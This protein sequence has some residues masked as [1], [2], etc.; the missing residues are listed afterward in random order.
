MSYSRGSRPP[1]PTSRS[2]SKPKYSSTAGGES[3]SKVR[4]AAAGRTPEPTPELESE[5]A[6]DAS[7][8]PAPRAASEPVLAETV[9]SHGSASS[10]AGV[11]HGVTRDVGTEHPKVIG[12]GTVSAATGKDLQGPPVKVGP[13]GLRPAGQGTAGGD[14]GVAEF[15]KRLAERKRAKRRLW[16]G[17][18]AGFLAIVAVLG[19]LAYLIGWSAA[20]GVKQE[21]IDIEGAQSGLQQDQVVATLQPYVGTPLIRV[22]VGEAADE[23]R[24]LPFVSE[25]S[26]SRAWPTGL[27]VLIEERLP[28]MVVPQADGYQVVGAD[29]VV[30]ETVPE[31]VAGLPT[32]V[33]A[34]TDPE[35]RQAQ[36]AEAF[37]IWVIIEDILGDRVASI[38]ADGSDFTVYL[39]GGEEIIW[40]TSDDSLLKAR[41]AEILL[42][43]RGATTY[44]VSYPPRPSTR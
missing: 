9:D 6:L 17:R 2:A 37:G 7:P 22:P 25:A 24:D 40:G 42:S 15:S 23:L 31:P 14:D 8:R 1:R 19:G 41:I 4:R 39:T 5:F 38:N 21:N 44:D 34:S 16:V 13:D 3:V 33:V 28:A 30:I 29:G 35:N 27:T 32:I 26:V 36:A 43:E 20:F 11:R 10:G 18:A 12:A